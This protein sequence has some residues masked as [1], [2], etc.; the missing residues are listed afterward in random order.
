MLTEERNNTR[1]SKWQTCIFWVNRP[2]LGFW[3][4]HWVFSENPLRCQIET[5]WYS[6]HTVH[7]VLS[8]QSTFDAE[9]AQTVFSCVIHTAVVRPVLM[10]ASWSRVINMH[11]S[12]SVDHVMCVMLIFDKKQFHSHWTVIGFQGLVL[13]IREPLKAVASAAGISVYSSV[14]FWWS[15]DLYWMSCGGFTSDWTVFCW[16]LSPSV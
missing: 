12:V 9:W 14:R 6:Y 2:C 5:E 15:M 11:V 13:T 4:Q 10:Y 8:S 7:S 3:T 16:S 1:V